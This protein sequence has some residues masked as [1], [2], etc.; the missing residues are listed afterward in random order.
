MI[1]KIIHFCWIS[2]ES[3]PQ[4]IQAYID[5]WKKMMPDYKIMKWDKSLFDINK[6]P[7]VKQAYEHRK[8]AFVADYIRVYALYN[9]GGIYLD[10]DVEVLKRF[11]DL[12]HLDM[13]LGYE[14]SSIKS[15]EVAVWGAKK[16]HPVLYDILKKLENRVFIKE[17]GSF[18]MQPLPIFVRNIIKESHKYTCKDVQSIE[19]CI[20][21]PDSYIYIF[22]FYY[23]SPKS[24]V[25]NQIMMN[26]KSYCIHH[27]K[28][29]WLV[30]K[31]RRKLAFIA[32][33][34]RNF[35]PIVAAINFIRH[36][37]GKPSLIGSSATKNSL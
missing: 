34:K 30:P 37:I 15:L 22:P 1:P 17:D 25:T 33:I 9:Y 31:I 6:V 23:F 24:H 29:S 36:L 35:P 18:D 13:M 11:D 2:E 21:S 4:D 28:A 20:N 27:F 3:L 10:S 16:G 8:W 32:Y 26:E 5:G 12:L 19:D 14:N 7:F